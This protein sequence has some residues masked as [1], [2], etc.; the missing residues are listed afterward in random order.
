MIRGPWEA[1][2]GTPFPIVDSIIM[3]RIIS[4]EYNPKSQ[5]EQCQVGPKQVPISA[6]NAVPGHKFLVTL[7]GT[8]L[9]PSSQMLHKEVRNLV[10][11]KAPHVSIIHSR[12]SLR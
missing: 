5:E 10:A 9:V 8:A 11:A 1:Q 4:I 12:T 6:M 7:E 2:C 3:D